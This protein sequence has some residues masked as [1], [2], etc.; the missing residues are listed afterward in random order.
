[1]SV[2]SPLRV[3]IVSNGNA[4]ST[5][6]IRP[7]V[8][9]PEIDMAGALIASVP[10][11][12]GGP[13]ATLWRLTRRT[14]VRFAMYKAFSLAAPAIAGRRFRARVFLRDLCRER[15]VPSRSVRSVNGEEAGAFLRRAAPDVIV[16]VS[17]PERILPE[18]LRLARVAPVN[19]HWALLPAYGGIAPYVW[20]LRNGERETGVTVHVMN[21]RLDTGPILRQR[22][23]EIT[24]D[25]TALSLQLRLASVAGEELHA[26]ILALPESLATAKEQPSEGRSY[27]TWPRRSD[28]RALRRRGRRLARWRD[29][30]SMWLE[31]RALRDPDA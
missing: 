28:V 12:R 27:Y 6:M 2:G 4:F 11:G 22:P 23:V 24:P 21:E 9:D 18:V 26:A 14:G 29:L 20:V 31:A 15:G 30:R 3:V 10:S 7:L 17:T 5:T 1:M 8:E 19:V 25:D 13:L 16:S